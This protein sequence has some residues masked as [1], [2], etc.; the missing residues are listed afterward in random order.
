VG[1]TVAAAVDA[2]RHPHLAL[3]TLGGP[4]YCGLLSSLAKALGAT[5]ICADYARFSK[6]EVAQKYRIQDFGD[7]AYLDAVARVPAEL[8]RRGLKI[9]RLVLIGASYA[10]FDVAELAA[11]HP[12]LHPAALVVVDSFLDLPAR[13]LA[14][15]RGHRTRRYMQLVLGGTLEQRRIRYASRSPSNHLKPLAALI[16]SGMSLVIAWSVAPSERHEFLGG[17]C[18]LTAD[19]AWVAELAT[20][21]GRPLVAQVTMLRHAD[22]LRNWGP[23]LLERAGLVPPLRDPLPGHA[24]TF[25][26]GQPAP[27][28]SYC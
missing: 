24:V 3:L 27:A 25:A 6:P 18:S 16:R 9:S 8:R 21:L 26:P 10:G 12:E 4:N 7:P 23:N 2:Y 20:I 15:P 22:L 11:T 17:T 19:A 1:L 13:Y 28:G 5:R 14:L